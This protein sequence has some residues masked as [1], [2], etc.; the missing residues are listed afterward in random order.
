MDFTF[1]HY[2]ATKGGVTAREIAQQP[3]MWQKTVEILEERLSE[4]TSFMERALSFEKLNIIFTGAGSSAFCAE[5]VFPGVNKYLGYN[6]TAIHTTDIVATPDSY[7]KAEIPTMLVS[8]GR[9][10]NSPESVAA[11]EYARKRVNDL[12]EVAITCAAEGKL[13]LMTGE[14]DYRMTINLPEETNDAGFA[15]TSSLT[16][17]ALAAY[18]VLAFGHFAQFKKDALFLSD[19]IGDKLQYLAD[20][21]K[22]IANVFDFDRAAFLGCGTLKG[23]AHEATVK[24]CELTTGVVNVVHD[25]SMGFRHG[26]KF[27]VKDNTITLHMISDDAL[28]RKYDLDF[29]KEVMAERGKNKVLVVSSKPVETFGAD[30]AVTFGVAFENDFFL[31][32]ANV[33]FAQLL[34]FFTSQK[35]GFHTDSPSV[36][37]PVANRVVQGVIIY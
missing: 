15:M 33:V 7:L 8:F 28:T 32:V 29:L 3:V 21:A 25:T 26:P 36:D 9:S 27:M 11:V 14:S 23:A 10:G 4:I 13:A 34:A 35:M 12:F 2:V 5:M 1:E 37:N 16:S 31:A 20:E 24:M 22:A 19:V 17:M 6:T 30:F 18:G